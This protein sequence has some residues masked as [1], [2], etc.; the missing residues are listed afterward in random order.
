MLFKFNNIP[1]DNVVDMSHRFRGPKIYNFSP[2]DF[3][4][5]SVQTIQSMF[6]DL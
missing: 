5:K 3:N 4:D 2:G 6:Q 1:L